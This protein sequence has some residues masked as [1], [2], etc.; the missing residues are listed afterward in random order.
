MPKWELKDAEEVRKKL[1]KEQEKEISALY[2]RVY[3]D[4]RKQFRAI[5]KDGTVSERIQRQYLDRLSRELKDAYKS[6]GEGLETEIRTQMTKA[7]EGVVKDAN[8]FNNRIGFYKKGAY[9]YV[10]KDI[11]ESVTTG[12]V[13]KG[14]WS[15]SSAIWSGIDKH[16]SDINKIIAEGIAQNKS[17]YDIAKDLEM[18]VDPAA[19]KPWDWSKVYP[20]TSKKID[21]N[22]QRLARTMVSH[23]YQQSLERVCKKNPFVTGYIWQSSGDSRTC[24][25]CADRDGEFFKKGDLPLDHPN[26]RCTFIAEIP[27]DYDEIA[28]RLADWA[29][30]K[31]D[32]DIDRWVED[33]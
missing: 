15:L 24:P 29:N 26:G 30:G 11:V 1:T 27:D 17:A 28:E 16:Q 32:P 7:S 21:Y 33:M 20:N 31:S 23:A 14:K 2:K 12:Q 19:R 13:Y 9:S 22:A 3:V 5:P 25:I 10:P 6:V 18:Y 4:T 8:K